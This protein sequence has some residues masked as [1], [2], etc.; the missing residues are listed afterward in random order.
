V[1][2]LGKTSVTYEVGVFEQGADDIRAIGGFTHV[3]VD[4]DTNRPIPEGMPA[5]VRSGLE[6]LFL[7]ERAKL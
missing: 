2:Q 7:K 5:E 1:S 3:F 6:K 4:K